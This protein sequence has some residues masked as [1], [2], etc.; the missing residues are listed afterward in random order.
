VLHLS[1]IPVGDDDARWLVAQPYHDAQ[2]DAVHAALEIETS[3]ERSGFAAPLT[4]DDRRAILRNL[5]DP[6]DGL[7]ELRGV[8]LREAEWRR[9]EG[10]A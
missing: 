4:V 7:A 9:R 6:P 8:L 1:G 5:N 3:L 10:L 2:A